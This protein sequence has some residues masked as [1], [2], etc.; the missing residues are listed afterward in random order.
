MELKDIK[1]LKNMIDFAA[2]R[3]PENDFLLFKDNGSVANKT[4]LQLQ[5]ASDAFSRL[6]ENRNMKGAHV[7]VVGP[8]C[9]EWIVT[10]FGTVAADSVI[11]PL[12][13]NETDDMNRQLCEFGDTDVLVFD[14]K[15]ESLC[16]LLHEKLPRVKLFISMDDAV[17]ADYVESFSSVLADNAGVFYG[18]PDPMRFCTL[19]FTSGT[20]GFPKGVMLNQHNLV[21][22]AMSVW[23]YDTAPRV[24]CCLPINHAYCFTTNITKIIFRGATVC[25]ND[26]MNNLLNDI[27]LFQ[28]QSIVC[29][30]LIANKL[31]GGALRY[32]KSKADMEESDAV[33][34]FLGG[35]GKIV[36]GGAPLEAAYNARY[37]QAGMIVLNGYGMTE[38]SPVI[39]NNTVTYWKHG[40]VGK[41]IPCMQ[42]KIANGEIL[43]KGAGVMMGYYKNEAATKE[44]F[45]EDG[46]LHT[47]DLGYIDEEGFLFIT[48]RC[49]NLI[50]LDNGENVSAE[51]LEERFANIPFVQ[52]VIAYGE[53][54]MICVEIFPNAEYIRKQGITDPEAVMRDILNT[55][56]ENLASFQRIAKFTLRDTPFE[57]TASSKIK[58]TGGKPT[59]KEEFVLP[60]TPAENRVCAA[61]CDVLNKE[62]VGMNENFFALGGDSLS[63]T[64][65]AVSLHIGTQLVYDHPVL[66]ELAAVL[67]TEN[68]QEDR[69]V[70]GINAVI[71][72]TA[73]QG[74]AAGEYKN[75]LLTGAT[76]FLGIH[77]LKELL[78]KNVDVYCLVRSETRFHEQ[79]K[80]YFNSLPL[81]RVHIVI[82][83]IEK[84]NLGINE[85]Q[86]N[87]L[88]RTID[89]VF[90]VAANVHHAGDYTD[91]KKTNVDGT[92]HCIDFA[93][94]ANAVLHHT[95]TVSVHG[96]AT[97][98]QTDK[99]AKF[100]EFTLDIGQKFTENVYIHSKYRAEEAVLVARKEGLQSNIYRI[101]NLTW[102][103]TDGV[104]QI[105][106]NDNGFLH[107]IHAM[108][109]LGLLS[110]VADKYPMDLTAVDECA[111]AFVGLA[112]SGRVNEIYHLM[113]PNY[114]S[115]E[116]LFKYL[117]VPYKKV[118]PL[119]LIETAFANTDDRD[120]HVYMFYMLISGRS[121][122][123]ETF[124]DFTLQRMN[125]LGLSWSIPEYNYLTVGNNCLPEEKYEIKPMHTGKATMTPIQKLFVSTLRKVQ[126]PDSILLIGENA[127]ADLCVK[128]KEDGI[129]SPLVVT[130]PLALEFEKIKTLLAEFDSACVFVDIPG[131]PTVNSVQK[132]LQMYVDNDCDCV[133]AVGGGAV[134]DC[135][136]VCALCAGNPGKSPDTVCGLFA[137]P[138]PAVPFYAV[139]TTAG[140]GSEVTVFAVL[141]DEEKQQKTPY[142]SD[143]FLPRVIASDASFTL[144][145]PAKMTAATGI[146]ALSHAVEAY[147]SLFAEDFPEDKENAPTACKMIFENL[148]TVCADPENLPARQNMLEAAYIAGKAFRRISTGY[149][150]A[151]AHRL[152][153][154]CHLPHG[155]AIAAAFVP[156]LRASLPHIAKPLAE[157]A[158]VCG[159]ADDGTSTLTAAEIFVAKCDELIAH[160]HLLDDVQFKNSDIAFI[161]DRAQDEVKSLGYPVVFTDEDL[162]EIVKDI[163]R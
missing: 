152:G 110:S 26:N 121:A 60:S 133:L 32:A 103:T 23:E 120:I 142:L 137:E 3:Y 101:G 126:L 130:F 84:E 163:M 47:G 122:N 153:E 146:D 113:N 129:R 105:N 161:V 78:A 83:N 81:D 143:K 118:S 157:L 72:E 88:C 25:V 106:T 92:V 134:L 145:L 139:P 160:L 66:G 54:G 46:W 77:I 7:A 68:A 109:K 97:V 136:K 154:L 51:F 42:V 140:T 96:A 108:V 64:E 11:I 20:T 98:P 89:A 15:H 149:I 1:T 94:R 27:R 93:K 67:E 107:R 99:T 135:A 2:D 44:A 61:V 162:A 128:M 132:A 35:C 85:V 155:V 45:T 19:L 124:C 14:K 50:L 52:E 148:P 38:C 31:M 117:G 131:E 114:L 76:G 30:P 59:K 127:V 138:A 91:L 70:T 75:I 49:K 65:L 10:Y 21:N 9:F 73:G 112:M 111:K 8:T 37:T 147:C 151:I 56:N 13:A 5:A 29:V 123:I 159:F 95:S 158:V 69:A 100:D 141:T 34:E 24:F 80:Y 125:A 87:E 90:H 86:Y 48:G 82:G 18:E 53:S 17:S 57:R 43:A 102:R 39:A 71:A 28:P 115:T 33:K 104:F 62:K 116:N 12:A 58:R 36:S 40:S 144:G 74:S 4:Y 6:L 16:R 63:A 22:S 41:P 55:V 119:A 79:I 156:V 150:H